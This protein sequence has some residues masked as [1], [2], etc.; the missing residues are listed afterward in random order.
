MLRIIGILFGLLLL[1][2]V[3]GAGAGL[4][5][6]YHYGRGL[7]DYQQL[8]DYEPPTVTRLHAGDGTLIA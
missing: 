8:A 4:Y 7:P 3:A 2:A 5:F 1:L 6:F